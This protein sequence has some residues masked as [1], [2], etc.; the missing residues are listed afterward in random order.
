MPRQRLASALTHGGA[1]SVVRVVGT[2][3]AVGLYDGTVSLRDKEGAERQAVDRPAGSPVWSVSWNPTRHE[4]DEQLAVA[5]WDQ[6]LS[7]YDA[8]GLQVGATRPLGFDPCCVRHFANGAYLVLGGSDRRCSLWTKDGVELT[9]LVERGDW[10]WTCVPRPGHNSVAVGCNDGT[11]AMCELIFSTVHGLC[12]EW[13]AHRDVMTDVVVHHVA[14][15]ARLRLRCRDYVRKV[16]VSAG[17]LLV[18]LPKVIN[19]YDLPSDEVAP[20]SWSARPTRQLALSL[21]CST[22]LALA[23]HFLLCCGDRLRL[24]TL[25]GVSEREWLFPAPIRCS[26]LVGG[27]AGR[28]G[29]LVGLEDG[30]V[31]RIFVDSPFAI[32]LLRHGACV[33]GLDLSASRGK[34]AVVDGERRLTVYRM[35]ARRDEQAAALFEEPHATAVVWNTEVDDMLCFSG[36]GLLSIKTGDFPVHQQR[37]IGV[38]VGLTGS[39][40]LSLNYTALA[41]VDVPRSATLYRYLEAK[42]YDAAYRVACLGVTEADWR[43]LANDALGALAIDVAR[44]AY[45]RLRD[46][47][48]IDLLATVDKQRKGKLAKNRLGALVKRASGSGGGLLAGAVQQA[49]AQSSDDALLSAVVLAHQGKYQ[50]AAKVW[51]KAGQVEKAIE[52]FSDLRM[53]SEAK[54]FSH[55][56]SADAAHALAKRQAQWAEEASWQGCPHRA[57]EPRP[58]P[59][60]RPPQVN[61]M[62]AA[63][64]TY[65]AAGETL[66]AIHILGG[67]GELASLH[68]LCR[69]RLSAS[70]GSELRVALDY[71]RRAG[72]Y[73]M[74]RSVLLKLGDVRGLLELQVEHKQWADAKELAER[75]PELSRLVH[76]PHAEW[77]ASQDQ[78]EQAHEA[79]RR[80]GRYDESCRLLRAL[81]HNAVVE[82]RFQDAGRLLWRL[83]ADSLMAAAEA[84]SH[85]QGEGVTAAA[86]DEFDAARRTAD[87]YYAYSAVYKYTDEPFT[88]LDPSAIFNT[89]RY[90]LSWLLRAEAPFGISKTYCLFAL[91]KQARALGADKLARLA[92]DKLAAY[93]VPPAWQE[94]I[95]LFALTVR[96]R[97]FRDAE[98]LLP[99]CYRCQTVNPPLNQNGDRCIACG[100]AFVR[101]F[102]SFEALPLVRFVPTHRC[103]ADE[104]LALLRRAP[105]P[106]Q[107]RA[108]AAN[109]WASEEGPDVQ[110]L[111]L[112]GD[113]ERVESDGA[114]DI[115]DPF[116]KA[117]L[118]FEPSADFT[119]TVATHE[120]LLA[121]DPSDVFVVEWPTHSSLEPEYYRSMV[122]EVPVVLCKACNHFFYEEDWELAVM[123]Q[124]ACPFC[125]APVGASYG[126]GSV[127]VAGK[128]EAHPKGGASREAPARAASWKAVGGA[129]SGGGGGGGASALADLL[130]RSAVKG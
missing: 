53:W 8:T 124:Q 65:L 92:L 12:R 83:S 38:V 7:F 32:R 106:R 34:L 104:V 5:S 36:P 4:E 62:A 116:T 10:V 27:P 35:P 24:F 97:P 67:Q 51:A 84:P 101:S 70:D 33:T 23:S 3:L 79:Y 123:Q 72:E 52:M 91:A 9:S 88:A 54:Q 28:E 6:S 109:P 114:L 40:I 59:T 58:S 55:T 122:P 115:N 22:L 2:C 31:Y 103:S 102:C 96:A 20:A 68:E 98:E 128:A 77:L 129:V 42:E 93:R 80:A 89:A 57:S 90:L 15:D 46:T 130:A 50:E 49:S 16:A 26:K 73:E 75:H 11:I 18:Q 71:L 74:A 105:P 94:Q 107:P 30:L 81:V 121:M 21:E 45:T 60:L 113:V 85:D 37:H 19:I 39:E 76:L 1:P 78:F 56:A 95:D 118:D 99:T 82:R 110:R 44:R 48:F 117:M 14:T 69:S 41:R 87:C 120:M 112:G 100:H 17:R 61:D 126:N 43:H 119:P 29:V 125:A 13:Y 127:S 64:E 66:K 108:E 25:K 86:R 63:A 47:R 111:A